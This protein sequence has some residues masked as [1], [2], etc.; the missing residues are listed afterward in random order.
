MPHSLVKVVL[1]AVVRA[2]PPHPHPDLLLV[3][4]VHAPAIPIVPSM[5]AAV[6]VKRR[7]GRW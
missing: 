2:H 7:R 1:G 3:Q 6:S 5:A 4:V